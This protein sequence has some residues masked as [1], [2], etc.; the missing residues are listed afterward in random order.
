MERGVVVAHGEMTPNTADL[1][2]C[3]YPAFVI[4]VSLPHLFSLLALIIRKPSPFL[5][6]DFSFPFL[7]TMRIISKLLLIEDFVEKPFSHELFAID[8]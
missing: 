4:F 8:A 2:S 3:M 7:R 6:T 5:R 1:S